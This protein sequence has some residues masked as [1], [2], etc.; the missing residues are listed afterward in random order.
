[1]AKYEIH[2]SCGHNGT[3]NL[4][5][6]SRFRRNRIGRLEDGVCF[7]CFKHASTTVAREQAQE[8]ELPTLLGTEKQIAWA[9][10]LR[11]QKLH[12]LEDCVEK[13]EESPNYRHIL[14]AVEHISNETSAKQWIEWRDDEP[15]YLIAKV[16]KALLA[17]PTDEQ[18]QAE[19]EAQK[20][21]DAVKRA[22]LVESTI[23]PET[24]VCEQP[25]EITCSGNTISVILPER[26]DDFREI[27]RSLDYAWKNGCWQ[28]S[29]GKFAG[30]LEDRFVELG[31]VLLAHG[32]LVRVF[33]EGLRARIVAGEFEPEQTRWITKLVK[34]DYAGWLMIQ[35]GRNEDYYDAA[36]KI[37]NSRYSRPCVVVPPVQFQQVLD[38]AQLYD[39]RLSDAA[40]EAVRLAQEDKENMLL[41]RKDAV[42]LP[43]KSLPVGTVP[44]VLAVPETVAVADDLRDED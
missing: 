28:R 34:G 3:V 21:A 23:R 17:V 27:V 2:Y 10:T 18:K 30:A 29:I 8:L 40:K 36:R 4:I 6:P 15:K 43:T 12:E 41:V 7:E 35:W 1:M 44:P 22:A 26:L 31:H 39:F 9:E 16:H 24:A 38:F 37:K 25:A 42:V 19:R 32:F 14:L 33:D 13:L 11:I 5:G 20:Q